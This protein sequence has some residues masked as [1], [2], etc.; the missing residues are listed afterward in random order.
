MNDDQTHFL[1]HIVDAQVE[2]GRSEDSERPVS[3]PLPEPVLGAIL[4]SAALQVGASFAFVATAS[5]VALTA[6]RYLA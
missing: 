3:E 6:F 4:G 5:V 1:E 2:L